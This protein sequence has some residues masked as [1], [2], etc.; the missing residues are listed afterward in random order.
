M[1]FLELMR[2][3]NWHVIILNQHKIEPIIL[4]ISK[5]KVGLKVSTNSDGDVVFRG[6]RKSNNQIKLEIIKS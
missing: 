3:A 5:L 2:G 1:Q 4:K 6:T